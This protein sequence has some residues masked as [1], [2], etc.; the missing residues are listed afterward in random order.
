MEQ[1]EIEARAEGKSLLVLDTAS[2][3]AERLYERLGWTRVGVIP[4][5][6]L[7]R[8]PAVRHGYLLESDLEATAGPRVG[9]PAMKMVSIV[10]NRRNTG[11]GNPWFPHEPPPS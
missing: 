3:T 11:V 5:W 1:A 2:D 10:G 9:W 7:P 8:R 6:P 4:N